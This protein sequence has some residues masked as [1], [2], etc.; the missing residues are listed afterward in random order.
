MESLTD[1]EILANAIDKAIVNGYDKGT[2]TPKQL[3]DCRKEIWFSHSFAKAFWGEKEVCL[4]D[5]SELTGSDKRTECILNR[6]FEWNSEFLPSW[7][8]HL[9]QI[10][11]EEEPIKY[12]AEF[13]EGS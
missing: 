11:R 12:L 1:R 9:M 10:I 4:L 13:L 8:Y 5:G 3:Y 2:L 7:E 6:H